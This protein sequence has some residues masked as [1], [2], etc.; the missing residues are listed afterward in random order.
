[1]EPLVSEEHVDYGADDDDDDNDQHS[2]TLVS[3][4]YKKKISQSIF[5]ICALVGDK[6]L[7]S[8]SYFFL[9]KGAFT[10]GI[11]DLMESLRDPQTLH[12]NINHSTAR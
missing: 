5:L 7:G 10:F 1:M 6:G 4:D 11:L 8:T 9:P 12:E 2:E 3:E